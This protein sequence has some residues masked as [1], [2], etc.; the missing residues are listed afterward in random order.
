MHPYQHVLEPLVVYIT[1]ASEQYKDKKY[2]GCYNVG[3]DDCDCIST[4]ELVSLF[5]QKWD[6]VQSGNV[7]MKKM[8]LMR[9]IY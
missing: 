8:H 3:P 5:C 9:Q 6:R 7:R 1:I 4:G 2:Q